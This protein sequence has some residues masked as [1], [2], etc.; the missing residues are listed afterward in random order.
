LHGKYH[1]IRGASGLLGRET[2]LA[3]RDAI[4]R[5]DAEIAEISAEKTKTRQNLRA[6]REPSGGI[7]A[8]SADELL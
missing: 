6:R 2:L 4:Q 3:L 8:G 1:D 7:E 5:R